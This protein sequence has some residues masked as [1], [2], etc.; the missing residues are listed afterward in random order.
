MSAQSFANIQ[1]RHFLRAAGVCIAMPVLEVTSTHADDT[2]AAPERVVAINIPLG[3]YGPDFFPAQVGRDYEIPPT[4]KPAESIRDHFTI[5]SGCS[6]PDVDG[7]HAAEVSFLTGAPHPGSRSFKNSISFDQMLARQI[8]SQTRFASLVLGEGSLSWNANGVSVP[9]EKQPEQVFRRLFM[10]GT[11]A[12]IKRA[13]Q[14]LENGHSILDNVLADAMA[15]QSRIS[16]ADR[17]KLDQYFTAVREAEERLQTAAE[18]S[19]KPL[20]D[21]DM[22]CPDPLPSE[23]VTGRLTVFFRVIRLALMT[24]STRIVTLCG[25]GGSLVPPI[26]GVEK[27]YHALTHHGKTSDMIGQLKKIDLETIRVWAEFIRS[28]NDTAEGNGTLLSRTQVL[29]GSNLG[30]ANA[31]TT[32]NLPLLLAGGRH[33]HGQHLAFDQTDNTPL[34]NVFVSITQSSGLPVDKFAS[35]TGALSGLLG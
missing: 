11:P 8:G 22:P 4:L 19:K 16:K 12:E 3:F 33:N 1:R 18:W 17:A 2:Q 25:H 23:D 7:G 5:I 34:A 32:T 15:M 28:L 20:P 30:N 29:L 10:K 9:S 24:D 35:S 21:V 31:H 27:G 6:H 13:A 26:A 14:R